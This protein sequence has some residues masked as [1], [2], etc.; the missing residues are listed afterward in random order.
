MCSWWLTHLWVW[1]LSGA[2]CVS[3]GS[4]IVGLVLARA[5]VCEWQLTH[6]GATMCLLLH[7]PVATPVSNGASAQIACRAAVGMSWHNNED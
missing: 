7:D 6:D 4:R 1:R 3:G 5:V 2:L